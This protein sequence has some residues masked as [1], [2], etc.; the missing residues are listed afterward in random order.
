[1]PRIIGTRCGV[2]TRLTGDRGGG[3]E[4]LDDFR[5]VPVAL[6]AVRLEVVGR[7]GE[8][9][10]H[11]GLAAGAGDAGLAVG[12]EMRGVDDARLEQRQEA[13]LHG[14][15]IAARIADDAGAA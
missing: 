11:L 1:M 13:Q 9:Q 3:V 10:S 15:R 2:K 5:M 8:E 6:D 4:A 7:L 14:G 12:D